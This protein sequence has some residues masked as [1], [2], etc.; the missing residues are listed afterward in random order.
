[1]LKTLMCC[2][3]LFGVLLGVCS[4]VYADAA[5]DLTEVYT[6]TGAPGE[7]KAPPSGGFHGFLGAALVNG[8]NI[9]GYDS[10]RKTGLAPIIFLRYSNDWLYWS[11]AGGG[12]WLAQSDDRSVKFGIGIKLHPGWRPHD[13]P[14]LAGMANRK[15]SVDGSVNFL[16]KTSVVNVGIN[17]YHDIGNVSNGDSATLRFSRTVLTIEKFRLTASIAGE[18]QDARL[19]DYYYGVRPDEVT[20][21]RPVYV[22]RD[23]VNVGAGLA[24]AYPLSKS[25]ALMGGV[26]TTYRGNG[27]TDSPI[28]TQRVSTFVYFGAGWRF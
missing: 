9:I 20:P 8:E 25:W 28:V 26:N 11:I 21:T 18:W 19:V 22:G 27:I 14:V 17:Y 3:L 23:T 4:T 24:G 1:M 16:W 10:G 2:M 12:V 6:A 15:S 5:A 13:D 7:E